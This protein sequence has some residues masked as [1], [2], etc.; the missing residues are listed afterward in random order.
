VTH[1]EIVRWF[2]RF[3]VDPAF[4]TESGACTIPIT[5]FCAFAG[6]NRAHFYRVIRGKATLTLAVNRRLTQAI[7]AIEDGLRWKPMRSGQKP[8]VSNKWV[9][10][11]PEKYQKLA[12]YDRLRGCQA[13]NT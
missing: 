10:V 11:N 3:R 8:G 7:R 9:M 5:E 13:A 2:R 6:V 12:R 4:R 1:E